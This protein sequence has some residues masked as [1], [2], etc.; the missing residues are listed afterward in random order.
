METQVK[1]FYRRCGEQH[2]FIGDVV[3]SMLFTTSPI[4]L[5]NLSLYVWDTL[6]MQLNRGMGT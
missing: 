5:F 3:N 4:K 1:Q 6:I 2:N